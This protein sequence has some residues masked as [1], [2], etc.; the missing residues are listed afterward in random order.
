MSDY[1]SYPV[2][3]DLDLSGGVDSYGRIN[4]VYNSDALNNA[5]LM[6]IASVEGETFRNPKKGGYITK[7]LG[8]PMRQ[9]NVDQFKMQIRNGFD[10]D[11]RPYLTIN[12]LEVIPHYEE[13]YWEIYMEV[14]SE[15]LKIYTDVSANIRNKA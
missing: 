14:Y 5:I 2:L 3:Y 15:D 12:A 10:R 7:L 1:S 6:W 11:F 4:E 8:K 13:K 9:T